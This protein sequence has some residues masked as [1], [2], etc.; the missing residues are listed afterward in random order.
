ML[1]LLLQKYKMNRNPIAFARQQGVKI[2]DS[3]KFITP[4]NLGSEPWLIEIGNHVELSGYVTFI[5]HDGSTWV[6][7]NEE[8]YKKVLKYGKIIIHDNCF[9]GMR[10]IIMPG[11]EIGENSI[12]G[13]GSVVTKSVPANSIYAGNPAHFICGLEDF[14]QK[15]LN[16][17]PEL[18]IEEYKRNKKKVV[19][20]LLENKMKF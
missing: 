7:R 4:P 15:C 1:K 11:V 17:T 18:D 12:I 13:A 6:F 9:I 3:C 14:K 19:L 2:G 16:N 20:E 10:T 8:K 5:T